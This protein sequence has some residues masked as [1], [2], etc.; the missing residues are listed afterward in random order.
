MVQFSVRNTR[1]ARERITS[2]RA[3]SNSK[4]AFLSVL[5]LIWLLS[6]STTFCNLLATSNETE[7][8]RQALLCFKSQI[9]SPVHVFVSWSNAS[10][11]FCNW[12]GVTCSALYPRRVI[13]INLPSEGITGLIPP[14]I[15]NLT[16][17]A[18]LQLSNNSF[19]GGIPSEFCLLRQLSYLNL[20][21][22]S[23]EGNIPADLSS[24]SQ[25]RIV[26]LWNNSLQGQIPP[27]LSQCRHLQEINLSNNKLQGSIPYAFGNLHELQI[28]D[29]SRNYLR[30][31]IPPALG[32]SLSLTYVD[33]GSN[34]LSGDIPESIA[35]CSSLQILKLMKNNLSGELPKAL[36][37]TSS[38]VVISLQQNQLVG[39]IP[40]VTAFSPP[41]KHLDLGENHLSGAIPSSIGKLSSLV[42]IYLNQNKLVGSIPECLA[43]ISTLQMLDF[44][45]NE[46]SGPVPKSLFNMSSLTYIYMAENYLIGR[47]PLDIGFMLPSIQGIVLT[48]NKFEGPIP[49]SLL[50]ASSLQLLELGNNSFGGFIP[51]FGSLLNLEVLDLGNNMLDAGDWAFMSSLSNCSKL[52]RLLLDGNNLQGKLP[53]SFGNLSKSIEMLWLR[54]NSISGPIPPEIGNLRNLN[55]L[56]MDYNLFIGNIP[57][58]IGNLRDLGALYLGHNKLSGQIPDAIGNLVQLT[59]LKLD[60]NNLSG[61]IPPTIGN[62]TQLQILNLTQNSLDG[63]IPS[64]IFKITT[65]EFYLSH[66]NLSGRIPEEVG[67]LINLKRLSIS[68]NLLS[69]NIPSNLGRCVVLEHLEMQNNY[70]A[71]SI[72][73][74]LANLVSIKDMDISVNNLSGDIPKFLASL[75]SLQHLN[76]SFN[77]FNGAVPRGGIF[78]NAG[79][80]SIEG[81]EHLCTSVPIRGMPPC[82]ALTSKQKKHKILALVLEIVISIVAAV[83]MIFSCLT[84]IHWRKIMQVKSNLPKLN[85]SINMITYREIANATERFSSSNLIGSGSF[86]VVYKGNLHNL[87]DQVAIKIFKLSIHGAERSFVAECEALR[88]LRHRN[89]VKIITLCSSVDYTGSAFK[90]LVFQYMPNGNLDSWLH[91]RAHDRQR[92]ILTLSQRINISLEVASALDY[93]HNQSATPLIHC[94]LKPS[95]VLLD[96]NLTAY[97]SD[98]G[99]ARFL[100]ATNAQQDCTS[101]LACLKGSIGYIPPEYGMNKAISTKGDVYSFGV[102][103]LEMITGSRPTD[104]KFSDGTDLHSF[105]ER[106]FPEKIDEIV[107]PTIL[108]DEIDAAEVVKNCIVPLVRI[109]LSCS[110]KLPKER[111]EMGRVHSEI[112]TVKEKFSSMN[113]S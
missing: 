49:T 108:Q 72:P 70:F 52:K 43:N 105:V 111:P 78:D 94:D 96:L 19:H 107:D 1:L 22:N 18:K 110:M 54:N 88:N 41:V 13:E 68:N 38:L 93:L 95:N 26:G 53:S 103:L 77:N 64:K 24:C 90:A 20:S 29:L 102:L 69:G 10:L 37:N 47:L 46:L 14:C 23:L 97:V 35:N 39:A 7:N 99:L 100:Y 92:D 25:L 63:S 33:L 21:I 9:S 98:F 112:L 32:S 30:G 73:Q 80:V 48:V 6:I 12:H 104:E 65:V 36:F 87:V 89:L 79:A 67:N 91:P 66:N 16:S 81:N 75:S 86:G 57:Q 40:P 109:G 60:G 82:S 76:L 51:L 61:R 58:K 71:G 5:A 83:I 8:D 85:K 55:E 74:S 28:L 44:N 62:C 56:F 106:A 34:A 3:L 101:T 11:E 4:M 113:D 42:S 45:E 84:A 27:A 59:E 50:N 17:L 2:H 15:T 31:N